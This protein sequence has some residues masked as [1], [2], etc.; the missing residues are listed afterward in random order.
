[1]P[2]LWMRKCFPAVNF[3][4]SNLPEQRYRMWKSQDEISELPDAQRR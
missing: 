4:N 2:E 1:M 3:A